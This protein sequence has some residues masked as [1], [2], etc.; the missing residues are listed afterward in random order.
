MVNIGDIGQ[1]EQKIADLDAAF[2]Y[3]CLRT[4]IHVIDQNRASGAGI[5]GWFRRC[6]VIQELL[7]T[8]A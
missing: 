6:V 1:A 4:P 5:C 3:T 8:T 2:P 7:D